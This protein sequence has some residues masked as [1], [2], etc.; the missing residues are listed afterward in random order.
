MQDHK[1][2]NYLRKLLEI[3]ENQ[4]LAASDLKALALSMGMD[5]EDWQA[6]RAAFADHVKRGLGYLQHKHWDDAIAELQEARALDP[7][8]TGVSFG[9]AQA[10]Q[11]RW[12][13]KGTAEDQRQASLFAKNTLDLDP[14]HLPSF[15]LLAEIKTATAPK[16]QTAPT[17][18]TLLRKGSLLLL[19]LAGVVTYFALNQNPHPNQNQNQNP[20]VLPL[21]EKPGAPGQVPVVFVP[22]A[23]AQG[24]R[25]R[26]VASELRHYAGQQSLSY[27]LRALVADPDSALAQ[28]SVQVEMIDQQG[29][30]Y[31]T[32]YRELIPSPSPVARPGDWTP[33]G[34]DY[35]KKDIPS[36]PQLKEI[37]ISVVNVARYGP[38]KS[39]PEDR[40]LTLG[41]KPPLGIEVEI[42]ERSSE[43]SHS[44]A[45][46]RTFQ[47]AVWA[48]KNN[49]NLPIELLKVRIDWLGATGQ[50]LAS[51]ESF[52]VT[53][54][55]PAIAPGELRVWSGTWG[56][57][58]LSPEQ[59]SD[60]R[61]TI[62]QAK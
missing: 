36:P 26:P 60:Y 18:S 20:A 30:A 24:L 7:Y 37:R 56:L 59:I 42:W 12:Q 9:L 46:K 32:Y 6:V 21:P 29:E 14:G 62:V 27:K 2:E 28:L 39:A 8:D 43:R 41:S 61:L 15:E 11:G 53:S 19:V 31:D 44:P 47:K 50:L 17:R 23:R 57:D 33:L 45:L 55:L 48:L 10:Y 49:G 3:Q 4:R 5:E 40:L 54:S 51:K 1:L 52:A 58:G 35:F 25:L 13:E 38:A 16:P 34:W 22:D